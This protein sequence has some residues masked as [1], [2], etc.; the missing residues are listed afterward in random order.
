VSTTEVPT[1]PI[2]QCHLALASL[3]RGDPRPY[4]AL[5]SH[6][7]DVTLGCPFGPVAC[8]WAK[9]E[10]VLDMA[11]TVY[12]DGETVGFQN[13]ATCVTGKLAYIVEIERFHARV[14]RAERI[15]PV[16]LRVTS[17]FRPEAGAWR[18]VHRHV[19]PITT[20]RPPYTVIEW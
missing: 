18:I 14:A 3:I 5:F 8:G 20:A 10:E 19:D 2:D 17:V 13:L 15:A 11:A 9:V 16:S 1:L 6:E 12:R 4:K 7:E